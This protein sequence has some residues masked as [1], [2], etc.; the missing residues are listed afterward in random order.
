[1]PTKGAAKITRRK[2]TKESKA[3]FDKS[4]ANYRS[5]LAYLVAQ[6]FR[7]NKEIVKAKLRLGAMNKKTEIGELPRQ[8]EAE[9]LEYRENR[10]KELM[11][12]ITVE[13][14]KLDDHKWMKEFEGLGPVTEAALLSKI[15]IDRLDSPSKFF[16]VTIGSIGENNLVMKPVEGHR[17]F[18][19]V[20]QALC[21]YTGQMGLIRRQPWRD[22]YLKYKAE[23]R[24]KF[25]KKIKIDGKTRYNDGH[26]HAMARRKMV[27]KWGIGL[28]R[29]WRTAH[30]FD[31]TQISGATTA[32]RRQTANA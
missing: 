13:V 23:Y 18:P 32:A 31:V 21:F 6:Y 20:K 30:G 12:A 8:M 3:A 7:E 15:D 27:Q 25:P 29:A 17:Y 5:T 10:K 9:H 2:K 22:L 19:Q 1:M 28:W 24:E 4:F 14:K 26:I 16:K 11:K